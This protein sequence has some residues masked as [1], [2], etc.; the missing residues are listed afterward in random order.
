MPITFS[1]AASA[2]AP[3]RTIVEDDSAGGHLNSQGNRLRLAITKPPSR[4]E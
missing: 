2:T 1:P 3:R 4:R